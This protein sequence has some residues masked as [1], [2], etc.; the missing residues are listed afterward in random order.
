MTFTLFFCNKQ[1]VLSYI[2]DTLVQWFP[3]CVYT[4]SCERS[5]QLIGKTFLMFNLVI[6]FEI[7]IQIF[8]I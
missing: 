3:K 5:L 2:F 8:I 6:I 7:D 1:G 4:P